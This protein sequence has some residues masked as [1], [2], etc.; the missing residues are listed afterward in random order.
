MRLVI[1][2]PGL[3][4]FSGHHFNYNNAI[5]KECQSRGIEL[6]IYADE[7][8]TED[9]LNALPVTPCFALNTYC[10]MEI[11]T[12][13]DMESKFNF[14]NAV[15][16][17]DLMAHVRRDLDSGD[18]I[19]FLTTTV[20]QIVGVLNWYSTLAEP[21]PAI[22][23][24]F[25]HQPWY[26]GLTS[27][28][29]YCTLL[30]QQ[31]MAAWRA[32]GHPRV[33][34]AADNELLAGFL[35]R[36]SGLPILL[37]PMPIR[38]PSLPGPTVASRSGPVRFGFLGDGRQEKGLH[39]FTNVILLQ[40]EAPLPKAEFFVHVS[41]EQGRNADQ[42]LGDVSNC[43]VLCQEVSNDG[44]WNLIDSCDVIVLP[45]DPKYY[46]IRG[47]GIVFE[48]MGMGK[49]VIV[50]AG[51]CL[52]WLLAKYG[53]SGLRCDYEPWSLLRAV[54]A[55]AKGFPDFA[56]IAEAAAPAIQAR[57]NPRNFMDVLLEPANWT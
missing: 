32:S 10:V 11:N 18:M 49:P 8:C 30:Q 45:Y 14:A 26:L 43:R 36:I 5:F 2:D 37:L 41:N 42:I 3:R 7:Q 46:H 47:S 6:S 56:A 48:A 51:S 12:K 53:G 27:D 28:P 50:T 29:E 54:E 15:L 16:E 1:L 38:Y 34:F 40:S 31:S 13:E 19:L 20:H 35:H 22:C 24:Q 57:H 39:H 9:V 52:D 4:E 21:K 44:Y 25:M 33:R 55:I 17:R 23:M